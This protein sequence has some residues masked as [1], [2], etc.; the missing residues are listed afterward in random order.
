MDNLSPKKIIMNAN[1]VNEKI[2]QSD[3]LKVVQIYQNTA[4]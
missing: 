3:W 4:V 1:E 2:L